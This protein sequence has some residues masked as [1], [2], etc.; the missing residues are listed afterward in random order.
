MKIT[1]IEP[2][3][4][5]L[6]LKRP[7]KM[8]GVEIAVSENVF[9]RIETDDGLVGWGE[10]SSS[11]SMTGE[12]VESMVAAIRFLAPFLEGRDP[13]A[14]EENLDEMDWRM[15][16]N[17]SAKTVLEMACYDL[18]GKAQQKPVS[19][20]LGGAKR[21]R[22]PVVQ[23]L[24]T[25]DLETDLADAR[26]RAEDGFAAMKIKVGGK[27]L[28]DDIARTVAIGKALNGAVQ[29]SADVNQ[30][31]RRE[32][33][34]EYVHGASAV[35]DFFEQP[36][37]GHDVEGMAMVAAE[38]DCPISADEGLHSFDDIRRHHEAG[39]AQGGS[40]KT[41]KLGGVTRAFQATELF[42]E[43]G[44][45][46][47]LAGKTAESSVASAAVLHIAAAAPN[48]NWGVSPTAPYLS[49]DVVRNPIEVRSGHV[50]APAGAG[51]GVEV[52]EDALARY[53]RSI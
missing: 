25:G 19:D 13:S 42:E 18:A 32:A 20:L 10:A 41:I 12:T 38:A 2:I 22:M 53:A 31:W 26:T 8:S 11:P 35:L 14:F 1:K 23:M 39:A 7:I 6:P 52:D 47:N 4:A 30:G 17:T 3:I 49:V 15:Y 40:L 28:A 34:I 27:P 48:L 36:V 46:V 21:G 29:L 51:L 43:L 37:M 44:M 24:A 16:G 9:A 50:E 33:A 5:D 45:N